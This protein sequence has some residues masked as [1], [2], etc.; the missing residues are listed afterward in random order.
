LLGGAFGKLPFQEAFGELSLRGRNLELRNGELRLAN[1]TISLAGQIP[2]QLS[3]LQLGPPSAALGLNLTVDG[4]DLSDL[5]GFLPAQST[6]GG[7]IDGRLAVAGTLADPQ[8]AGTVALANGRFSAPFERQPI[9]DGR[10][11][12]TLSGRSVSIDRLHANVGGGSVDGSGH[13]TISPAATGATLAYHADLTAKGARLDVPAL[14]QGTIDAKLALQAAAH[15]AAL[16]SGNATLSNAA[17]SLSGL[18]AI[19]TGGGGAAGGLA[20][21]VP[22]GLDL[23]LHAVAGRNVRV[24]GSGIDIGAAGSMAVS[25]SLADPQLAA[26]FEATNGTI[27]YFDRVFRIDRAT[28]SFDPASGPVP[29]INAVASTRV[30][31]VSPSVSVTLTATGPA[32]NMN[33]HFKSDGP[34]NQQQI[35]A[36]LLD[37]PTLTG[38]TLTP[39]Q[40]ASEQANIPGGTLPGLKGAPPV[41][42]MP[43][44]VLPPGS[45]EQTPGG[46]LNVSSEALSILNAQFGR[47]LLAPLSGALGLQNISFS[48]EQGGAVALDLRKTLS[49]RLAF[50]YDESFAMPYRQ[51]VGVDYFPAE[52]T[53]LNFQYFQ[54]ASTSLQ[55][56]LTSNTTNPHVGPGVPIVGTSGWALSVRRLFP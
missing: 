1:G 28:L 52:N 21:A 49:D 33:V 47:S 27:S 5:G 10:A 8:V 11:T 19:A 51:A 6:I 48:F 3:P 40:G 4:V 45:V 26:M 55:N 56:Q 17:L 29:F 7:R 42:T 50:T 23:D 15:R 31:S 12:V 35:V 30:T 32:T 22:L 14:G 39:E 18:Y 25:G 54:Q 13:L 2:L 37:F 53:L 44:G 9:T 24:Q 34:Y 20:Y 38:Q 16:L 46:G 43:A 41:P 36:L